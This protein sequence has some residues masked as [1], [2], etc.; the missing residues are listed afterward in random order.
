MEQAKLLVSYRVL[1]DE[2]SEFDIV[3]RKNRA[4]AECILIEQGGYFISVTASQREA[5]INALRSA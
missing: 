2:D 4:D 3:V 5:L 1:N